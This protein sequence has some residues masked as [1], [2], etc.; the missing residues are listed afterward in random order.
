METDDMKFSKL[1]CL[2]CKELIMV[3]EKTSEVL[4]YNIHMTL[5]VGWLLCCLL[6]LIHIMLA[7]VWVLT[8]LTSTDVVSAKYT[9]NSCL[10]STYVWKR[11][12]KN[13]KFLFVFLLFEL[14]EVLTLYIFPNI[15]AVW[16]KNLCFFFSIYVF[17]RI[18]IGEL[19]VEP[20]KKIH[21]WRNF[22]LKITFW[23]S[24]SCN[25]RQRNKT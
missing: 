10:T 6:V 19:W 9:S 24:Q 11:A 15:Y 18:Q 23:A 5:F 3:I 7:I 13:S 1:Y 14:F 21:R 22:H 8:C 17:Q 2:F 12:W 25:L 16:W 20:H 4:H